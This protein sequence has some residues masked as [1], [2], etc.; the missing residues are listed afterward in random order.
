VPG[1]LPTPPPRP[2]GPRLARI[3]GPRAAPGPRRRGGTRSRPSACA[4]A[5]PRTGPEGARGGCSRL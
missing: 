5:T 3:P 1:I 4:P 2:A